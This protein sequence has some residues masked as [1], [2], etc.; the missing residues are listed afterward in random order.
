MPKLRGYVLTYPKAHA[1]LL[2][3]ADDDPL[4]ASWRFGLG[5]VV[6]FTSD[7]SGRWGREWVQW[8]EFPRLAAQLAR[9]VRRKTTDDRVK[10]EIHQQEDEVQTVADVSLP[11]GGFGNHLSL[12]GAISGRDQAT[13]PRLMRQIGPGRYEARF[14]GLKRGIHILSV[15]EAEN[16]SESPVAQTLPFI[17]SYSREYHD[18]Q[19]NNALLS[20]L[21]EATGGEILDR[22]KLD[23]GVKRLVT[24]APNA[25]QAAQETWWALSGFGLLLFLG[26]LALR[27]WPVR[28]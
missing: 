10:I 16:D 28:P 4:L 14:S 22:E 13:Q 24:P 11:G 21:A 17:S 25:K 2:V 20:K 6:A 3:K 15:Y 18:L 12:K 7:L 5:R 26:D 8:S 1:D 19:P 23:E 27:R 9:S